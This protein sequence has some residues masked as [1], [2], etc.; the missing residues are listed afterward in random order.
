MKNNKF[1]D[2]YSAKLGFV[3]VDITPNK[4]VETVGFGRKDEISRGVLKPL[5]A[6]ISLWEFKDKKYCLIAIDHICFLTDHADLLRTDIGNILNIKKE[7]VMICFSHTHSAPNETAEIEYFRFACSQIKS[8]IKEDIKD[9]TPVKVGWGNAYGDI[10][11]NRRDNCDK[12]NEKIDRRIGILKVTD[13][14]SG[15]LRLL[16]LRLTAHSNVLKADNYM[17]SPDYFG[18]VRELLVS[19]YNCHI[20]VTQGASGN[21]SPKHFNSN[22]DFVIDAQNNK[23]FVRSKTALED[24][25]KEVYEN[26]DKVINLIETKNTTNLEIY[27]VYK[28]FY[29]EVPTYERALEI[30]KEAKIECNIDGT[31]WLKEVKKLIHAKVEKQ[32]DNMEIQYFVLNNGCL[33]GVANEIMCEL[34]LS[35][36][37]IMNNDKFY[38]GGYTNGCTGYLPTEYEFDEGGY[39]VYWSMLIYYIYYR[40][41][42]PLNRNSATI[43]IET[44][45]Q[46][47]QKHLIHN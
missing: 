33:C 31:R 36:M 7:N 29:S 24:M 43:L 46:N 3:E 1:N 9:M 21:V 12:S 37:T 47:V 15:Q 20:M 30:A 28:E 27:S 13:A 4:P 11:I 16:L 18:A 8:G 35:A 22:L 34:A 6:Q 2:R 45:V 14:D 32:I 26:V 44:A 39:E 42:F 38:L 19:K 41:V 10:G 23:K 40:R 17:I 25:A 5:L